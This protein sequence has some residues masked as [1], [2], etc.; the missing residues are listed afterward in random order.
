MMRKWSHHGHISLINLVTPMVAVKPYRSTTTTT[1]INTKAKTR[2][3]GRVT[4]A[5]DRFNMDQAR[6]RAESLYER[7][8]QL[9]VTEE[10][11][12]AP[13]V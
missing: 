10:T 2:R 1:A 13:R 6:Y 3:L 9:Q 12:I 4:A 7:Q 11:T 5:L 8:T